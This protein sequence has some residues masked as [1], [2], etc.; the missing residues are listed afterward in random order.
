[1]SRLGRIAAAVVLI[2]AVAG[3]SA[4]VL[5]AVVVDGGTGKVCG[6]PWT[7]GRGS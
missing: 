6:I 1:M 3:P 5:G 7:D 4:V 2:A